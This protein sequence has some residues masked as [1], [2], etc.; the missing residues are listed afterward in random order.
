MLHYIERRNNMKI[1]VVVDMQN[2][3]ITGALGTKEAQAIVPKIQQKIDQYRRED[4]F[5]LFTQD[6]HNENYLNTQEGKHL[7][8]PHCIYG[9]YGWQL[10]YTADDRNVIQKCTFGSRELASRIHLRTHPL[11]DNPSI[12]SVELV[13]VCTGICVLSNAVLIKTM[14]P[15]IPIVVDASC[16]ACV[17]PESH[18]TAL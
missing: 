15:E 10:V 12:E 17:T 16:C 13:G 1:L 14:S 2:D 6:T 9:S 7:P 8:I 3:F 18:K 5:V 4:N 11:L